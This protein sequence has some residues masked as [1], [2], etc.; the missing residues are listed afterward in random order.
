MR[1][2]PDF[3]FPREIPAGMPIS[4]SPYFRAV[5]WRSRGLGAFA[6]LTALVGVAPLCLFTYL[7]L[8]T[9]QLS[10]LLSFWGLFLGLVFFAAHQFRFF[11]E[12]Q[13]VDHRVLYRR[14]GWPT[15]QWDEPLAGYRGIWF[16]GEKDRY[17]VCFVH[18]SDFSRNFDLVY[19]RPDKADSVE[20]LRNLWKARASKLG[21]R[22]LDA[23][24]SALEAIRQ[25]WLRRSWMWT[26]NIIAGFLFLIILVSSSWPVRALW[27]CHRARSWKD[28]P[29]HIVS[30]SLETRVYWHGLFSVRSPK[31][32]YS[33]AGGNGAHVSD[34]FSFFDEGNDRLSR[35]YFAFF[36]PIVYGKN[37]NRSILARYPVGSAQS[38]RV[39]ISRPENVVLELFP[40][41]SRWFW[42]QLAFPTFASSLAILIG[43]WLSRTWGWLKKRL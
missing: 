11:E 36:P 9:H 37:E 38:A 10:G 43:L 41:R 17:L 34:R 23:G 31:I 8:V 33:Y 39:D 5:K 2:T 24:D 14:S 42:L 25:A 16:R 40:S 13:V 30:T 4:T 22:W 32:T 15:L 12:V 6:A 1:P 35:F 19:A 27:L 3:Y 26:R 21:L 28:L 18:G 20:E 7:A 29:V